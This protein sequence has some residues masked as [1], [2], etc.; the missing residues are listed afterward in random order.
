MHDRAITRNLICCHLDL[1]HFF[2]D[3]TDRKKVFTAIIANRWPVP[4]GSGHSGEVAQI[5]TPW[6]ISKVLAD[7]LTRPLSK[8]RRKDQMSTG[9]VT[10]HSNRAQWGTELQ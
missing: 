10:G 4:G 8:G 5:L 9:W 2:F 6:G 7:S 3:I 1:E